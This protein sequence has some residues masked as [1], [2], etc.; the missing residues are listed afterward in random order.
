MVYTNFKEQELIPRERKVELDSD[1]LTSITCTWRSVVT[2]EDS[3]VVKTPFEF[4]SGPESGTIYI[5]WQ[6]I[7]F[8]EG[9]HHWICV[10]SAL[11]SI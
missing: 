10:R 1:E 5:H 9:A 6:I 2:Q 4:E 7:C 8:L 11:R 3:F